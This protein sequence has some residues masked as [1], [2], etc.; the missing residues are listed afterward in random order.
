MATVVRDDSSGKLYVLVGMGY[1]FAK[2]RAA[3]PLGM[4]SGRP[5]SS[6]NEVAAVA[7]SDGEISWVPSFQHSVVSVD[8]RSCRDL[9]GET[10][11]QL[12]RE[13]ENSN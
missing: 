5:L 6:E 7:D 4:D 8:G 10:R 1:G 2:I 9:I 12:R 13:S 11:E 3:D